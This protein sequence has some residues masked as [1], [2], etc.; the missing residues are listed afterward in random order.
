MKTGKEEEIAQILYKTVA[1]NEYVKLL[2]IEFKELKEGY[3]RAE[4]K[5]KKNWQ[6]LMECFMGEVCIP[7]QILWPERRHV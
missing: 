6:I 2:G 1:Q 4:M 3:C 7:W 5:Y